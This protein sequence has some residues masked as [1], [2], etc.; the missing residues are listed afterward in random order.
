VSFTENPAVFLLAN[1]TDKGRMKPVLVTALLAVLVLVDGEGSGESWS[2][3]EDYDD[4]W[5]DM[6]DGSG[7]WDLLDP[8]GDD[9]S[10]DDIIHLGEVDLPGRTFDLDRLNYPMDYDEDYAYTELYDTQDESVLR[11]EDVTINDI[12]IRPKP[13]SSDRD[14]VLLET[15]QIFIM[16]GSAFVSFAI[17]ML[18]FFLCRRMVAKK[19]E[20]KKHIPFIVV[21]DRKLVKESSIVKD[22]QKVPT[23]TKQILQNSRIDM[24]SGDPQQENPSAAPLVS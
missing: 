9:E 14:E 6:Q 7:D 13:D 4:G 11:I 8:R 21:P 19:Q 15:S 3:L 18:T 17:F 22:Y 23:T 2:D 5:S 24:Y 20:K 1:R 10:F 12:E 16:V